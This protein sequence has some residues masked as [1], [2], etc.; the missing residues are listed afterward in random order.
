MNYTDKQLKRAL[1][2][3]REIKLTNSNQVATVDACDFDL[4]SAYEWRLETNG[5]VVSGNPRHGNY[6]FL[7][8]VL[9]TAPPN[10]VVDHR[11]RQP[12][13]NQRSN[14]RVASKSQ[15]AANSKQRVDNKSGY[16][17]VSFYLRD[18]KWKAQIK[19]DGK[20]IFLGYFLEATDAAEAYNRAALRHFGEF[21]QL[22][23]IALAKVKGIEI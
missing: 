14:L 20:V 22:N 9:I 3:M 19:V 5:Y 16:R 8:S 23:T 10:F 2:K 4:V 12:L 15:N 17:G 21:A 7:H 18:S 6:I 11:D 1:A 13:N